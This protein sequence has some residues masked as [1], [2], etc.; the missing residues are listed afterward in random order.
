MDVRNCQRFEDFELSHKLQDAVL[1]ARLERP[2][3]LQKEV[4]PLALQ[5]RDVMFEAR[6][7]MG[8]SAC[9]AIPF[10]QHWLR[11]RGRKAIIIT[12]TGDTVQQLGKVIS[13]LCP[14]LKARV[15]KFT[16]RDDYFYPEFHDK[17]PIVILEYAVADRFLKREKEFVA[18]VRSVGLDEFDRMLDN[19]KELGAMVQAISPD[20]QTLICAN[21]LTEQIVEKGRWFCD[22]SRM[23]KVK[24]SRPEAQW[25]QDQVSL[26]YLLVTDE[27]RFVQLADLARTSDT[28]VVMVLTDSD[29]VSRDLAERFQN[30]QIPSDLL[31]YSMQLDAKQAIVD[32][33][34]AAGKGILVGCEASL[35][36]LTMPKVD[37]LVSW[38]LPSQLENYWKRLDRFTGQGQLRATVL[39]DQ[40]RSG[41][42]RILERRLGR[43][44]V[45]LNPAA[46]PQDRGPRREPS[47]RESKPAKP[48]KDDYHP[49]PRPTPAP[50]PVKKIAAPPAPKPTTTTAP[51]PVTVEPAPVGYIL[52]QRYV[53]PVFARDEELARFAPDGI[54]KKTLGDRFVPTRGKKKGK[55]AP[56]E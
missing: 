24:L 3:D 8:K 12:P 35:N 13:R 52:P 19:E 25:A 33:V 26:E 9:F 53:W 39:V 21:E 30:A 40:A 37:H 22:S 42:V 5:N 23:E 10:L 16:K 4:I 29:R 54:V 47:F 1:E 11:D 48:E 2:T 38:E 20:R 34:A 27:K 7:G 56:Q 41:A 28:K 43:N 36:G 46:M 51:K 31:E 18:Q 55:P 49:A 32:R 14:T 45:C 50:A 6:S 17:C 44:M 15:L